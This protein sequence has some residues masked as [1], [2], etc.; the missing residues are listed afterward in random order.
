[1]F[2]MYNLLKE[3]CKEKGTSISQLCIE[4]TGNSGNLATWKKGYMRSDYLA[5][6]ADVLGVSADLLLGRESAAPARF[7]SRI[8]AFNDLDQLSD[9]E[10]KV[11][12]SVIN[13][14]K[15]AHRHSEG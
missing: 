14:I 6:C 3:L 7:P 12:Q 10:L 2:D 1:M 13:A 5:K 4:V 15:E 11:I 8:A 9:T